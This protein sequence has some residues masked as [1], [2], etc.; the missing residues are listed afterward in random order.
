M[1]EKTTRVERDSIGEMNIPV[2]AYYGVQSM[3]AL[4]NFL[5]SGY[6]LRPEMID[7]LAEVK[8]ACAIANFKAGQILFGA[9]L[10][11]KSTG[12]RCVPWCSSWNTACCASVP[13][14]PQVI[15]AVGPSTGE[16]STFT[17]LPFDSI[18]SCWR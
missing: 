10:A 6:H 1:S 11:M 14:P 8:K 12:I 13:T 18:S 4:E 17:L 7:S 5:I 16:P 15:A 2:E 9:M 3:R